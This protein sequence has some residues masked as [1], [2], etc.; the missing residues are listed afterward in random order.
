VITPTPPSLQERTEESIPRE[1][2][3]RAYRGYQL[4]RTDRARITPVGDDVYTVPSCTGSGS[5]TVHYGGDEESCTCTDHQVQ[6][7]LACK[8]LVAGSMMH[9]VRCSGVDEIRTIAA[10]AGDPFSYA[11]KRGSCP[12]FC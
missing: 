11:S 2:T 1:V 10:A 7:D 4:W 3:S 9:A 5:Y 6:P 12:S 8:H